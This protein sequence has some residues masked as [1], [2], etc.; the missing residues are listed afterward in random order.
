MKKYNDFL[1]SAQTLYK[2]YLD[3]GVPAEDARYLLPNASAT[4]IIVT[5]NARELR[6]FFAL[7]C[8]NR[9]QW[10]IRDMAC[11]MLNLAKKA[12]PLLFADA[13]PDC[14]RDGCNETFPCGKPWKNSKNIK[15]EEIS[16]IAFNSIVVYYI[17]CLLP[18]IK[19]KIC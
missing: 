3:A 15:N 14:A 12:A 1:N 19:C 6:H 13:G 7:R 2:E 5:M 4:K 17:I 8:C 9:A 10:E 16:D 18:C 11:K